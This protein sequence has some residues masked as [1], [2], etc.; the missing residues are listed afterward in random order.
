MELNPA[1]LTCGGYYRILN[2]GLS[3]QHSNQCFCQANV[4]HLIDHMSSV[5]LIDDT[6]TKPSCNMAVNT[7]H[8]LVNKN[9]FHQLFY[10]CHHLVEKSLCI[11]IGAYSPAGR[12]FCHF[13]NR[14]NVPCRWI[15]TSCLDLFMPWRNGIQS[16]HLHTFVTCCFSEK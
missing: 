10:K 14:E 4:K 7:G 16:R 8:V 6:H 5:Q 1:T 11:R 9:Y 2:T 12:F 3:C 15:S 13:N